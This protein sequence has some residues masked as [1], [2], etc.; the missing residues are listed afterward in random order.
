MLFVYPSVKKDSIK[1][2]NFWDNL[3]KSKIPQA[4]Y[5]LGVAYKN[6]IGVPVNIELSNFWYKSAALTTAEI[7]NNYHLGIEAKL[8]N[9]HN[10]NRIE[11]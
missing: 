8:N 3:A 6:G 4:Q 11:K 1:A 9:E 7:L 10:L 5:M 2:I